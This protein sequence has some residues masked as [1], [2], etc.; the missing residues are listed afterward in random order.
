MNRRLS[1][2][3]MALAVNF[4]GY[5]QGLV[6][7][8]LPLYN[9]VTEKEITIESFSSHTAVVLVFT[10]IHCPYS[11]LY[12]DRISALSMKYEDQNVRFVLINS[13]AADPANKETLAHMKAEA[14]TLDNILYFADR[15]QLIK[16][17]MKAEKNPEVV[18]LI[19]S[20]K[21]YRKIYQGAIDDSPQSETLVRKNY[22]QVALNNF[23][24]TQIAVA[25]YQRPIG[26]RI[27]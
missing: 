22:V 16:N 14:Q 17:A 26:C 20:G 10:S 12:K 18:I 24:S 23:L 19:P 13:N 6:S 1:L 3:S 4:Y 9:V 11:K 27:R 15:K 2:I 5:A 21:N 25:D 7:K 8:D